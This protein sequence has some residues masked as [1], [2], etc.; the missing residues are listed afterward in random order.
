MNEEQ[1]RK[2][3]EEWAVKE[4]G[5]SIERFEEEP[6]QYVENNTYIA[7]VAWKASRQGLVVELPYYSFT[8]YDDNG[9]YDYGYNTCLQDIKSALEEQGIKCK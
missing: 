9:Q 2:D 3:F 6:R 8:D 4:R 1:M 7:W 5:Y